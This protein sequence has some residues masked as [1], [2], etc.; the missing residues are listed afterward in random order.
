ME[1]SGKFEFLRNIDK[2][3]QRSERW[4]KDATERKDWSDVDHYSGQKKA[5][6][7]VRDMIFDQ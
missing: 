1:L 3:I 2:L 5:F 4:I 7:E 6:E